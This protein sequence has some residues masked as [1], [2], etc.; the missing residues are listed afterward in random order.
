M[1]I[2]TITCR[3]CGDNHLT[4]HCGKPK[5]NIKLTDINDVK[6]I[7]VKP[8]QHDNVY[9]RKPLYKVC[10][11]NLPS[12][13]SEEELRELLYDWGHIVRLRLLT[14][15]EN[16]TAY[17]EFKNEEEADYL[18]KAL[19]KTPFESVILHVTRLSD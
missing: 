18:V 8:K 1:N 13:M 3:K 2:Q 4:A 11:N 16:C 5:S 7:D 19:N 6:P 10:I 17:V 15:P 12:D 14:Y 9:E